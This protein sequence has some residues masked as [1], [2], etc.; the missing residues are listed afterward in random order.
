MKSIITT[1]AKTKMV[2]ARNG[3]IP[4]PRVAGI[5]LGSGAVNADGTLQEPMATENQLK[6]EILRREYVSCAK[7]SDTCYRYRIELGADELAGEV[8]TEMALY[9]TDGDLLAIR[10][11][12]GKQKDMDMEMAF[13]FDDKFI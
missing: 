4:L 13:E 3:E 6:N 7:I 8:I 10:V 2:Q 9:D 11:F 5:A 12:A 1:I